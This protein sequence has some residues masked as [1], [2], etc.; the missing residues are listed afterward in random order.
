MVVSLSYRGNISLFHYPRLSNFCPSVAVA[1][2][3]NSGLTPLYHNVL[4]KSVFGDL[5]VKIDILVR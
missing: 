4:L 1:N 2:S 5:K 3:V